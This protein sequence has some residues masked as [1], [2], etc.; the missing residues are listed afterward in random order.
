MELLTELNRDGATIV[1]VTHSP[2]SPTTGAGGSELLDGR[3]VD[4]VRKGN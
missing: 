1:L 3:I 4:Q 2:S